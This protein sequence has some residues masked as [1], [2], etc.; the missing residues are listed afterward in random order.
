MGRTI[1]R[2]SQYLAFVPVKGCAY[3]SI[4][5]LQGMQQVIRTCPPQTGRTVSRPSENMAF[6][7]IKYSASYAALVQQ[8]IH[9]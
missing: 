5:M 6:V 1:V 3:Y 7:L 8:S 9:P 4:R 2:P